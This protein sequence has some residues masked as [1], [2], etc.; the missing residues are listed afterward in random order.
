M[1]FTVTTYTWT[2]TKILNKVP[3]LA[4][5]AVHVAFSPSKVAADRLAREAIRPTNANHFHAVAITRSPRGVP[6]VFGR[7]PSVQRLAEVTHL[8][9]GELLAYYR[10][11]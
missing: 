10:T 7:R 8:L 3:T 4:N 9:S 2:Q 1:A 5:F 11:L 6:R